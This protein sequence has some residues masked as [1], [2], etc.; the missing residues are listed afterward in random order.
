ME[1]YNV[2]LLLR[3]NRQHVVW[4]WHDPGGIL[5]SILRRSAMRSLFPRMCEKNDN[6]R[7]DASEKTSRSWNQRLWGARLSILQ[8]KCPLPNGPSCQKTEMHFTHKRQML[9]TVLLLI[10]HCFVIND[11]KYFTKVN[12]LNIPT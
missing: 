3:D 2:H 5:S 9:N 10:I 11:F 1:Y 12:F 8:G 7:W 6:R 4:R